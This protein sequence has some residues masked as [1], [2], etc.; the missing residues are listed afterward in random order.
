MFEEEL[1][2]NVMERYNNE[3]EAEIYTKISRIFIEEHLKLLKKHENQVNTQI[4]SVSS[5]LKSLGSN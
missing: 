4:D 5:M 2:N 3:L 1:L